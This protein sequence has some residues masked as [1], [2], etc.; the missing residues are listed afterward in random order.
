MGAKT[1]D[2]LKDNLGVLGW[3]LTED[4]MK[5]LDKASAIEVP[6]PWNHHS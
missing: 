2:Q 6:Y 5:E 4:Q 1:L 3:Q